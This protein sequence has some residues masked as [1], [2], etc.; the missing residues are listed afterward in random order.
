MIKKIREPDDDEYDPQTR[1]A[2]N[3]E[4]RHLL[5]ADDNLHYANLSSPLV[6]FLTIAPE[7]DYSVGV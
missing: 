3:R 6:S 4:E 2:D 5:I 1:M 7:S